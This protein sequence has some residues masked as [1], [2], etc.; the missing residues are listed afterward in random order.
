[1]NKSIYRKVTEMY[2]NSIE[3]YIFYELQSQKE[4][5]QEA[6]ERRAVNKILQKIIGDNHFVW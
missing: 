1:M 5:I 4:K 6:M 2:I 3:F